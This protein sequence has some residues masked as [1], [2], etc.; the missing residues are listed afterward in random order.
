MC[1]EL[2]KGTSGRAGTIPKRCRAISHGIMQ[3]S[4]SYGA[5]GQVDGPPEPNSDLPSGRLLGTGP[6]LKERGENHGYTRHW[7]TRWR[8]RWHPRWHPRG[9][10][11]CKLSWLRKDQGLV[12]SVFPN[13]ECPVVMVRGCRGLRAVLPLAS[14]E[15]HSF[16]PSRCVAVRCA[17]RLGHCSASGA[18]SGRFICC[19]NG[20]P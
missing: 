4:R 11:V 2:G 3:I 1:R 12:V 19:S 10:F 7:R 14:R 13:S 9:R 15:P 17:N 20:T 16:L 5:I 8:T 18:K 6:A